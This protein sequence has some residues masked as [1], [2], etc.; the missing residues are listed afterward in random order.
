MIRDQSRRSL[1]WRVLDCNRKRIPQ[2]LE[3]LPH[4]HWFKQLPGWDSRRMVET[5]PLPSLAERACWLLLTC[6]SGDWLSVKF[7]S[8]Y[9]P[10]RDAPNSPPD[11]PDGSW[12]AA[13]RKWEG[14]KLPSTTFHHLF[15]LAVTVTACI[16]PSLITEM[17]WS[18]DNLAL[19]GKWRISGNCGDCQQFGPPLIRLPCWVI[20][21]SANY[22]LS[23]TCHIASLSPNS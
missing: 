6:C 2:H 8:S 20:S 13:S 16:L 9:W 1:W 23:R 17:L 3:A 18:M 19:G 4:L 14:G 21:G 22:I 7:H 11:H 12:G 15:G 5:R 10:P